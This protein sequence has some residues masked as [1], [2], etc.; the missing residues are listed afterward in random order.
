[1]VAAELDIPVLINWSN[2]NIILHDILFQFP[3]HFL[4]ARTLTT[5]N[6]TNFFGYKY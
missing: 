3:P 6:P 5:A 4:T 2:R 1:M